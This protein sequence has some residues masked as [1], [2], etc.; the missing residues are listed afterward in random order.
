MAVQA[1]WWAQSGGGATGRAPVLGDVP[2]Q[3]IGTAS[4]AIADVA[5]VDSGAGGDDATHVTA[6]N[7]I[8]AALESAGIVLP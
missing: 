1:D 8:I 5:S 4:A 3:D 6:T 2:P 7:A